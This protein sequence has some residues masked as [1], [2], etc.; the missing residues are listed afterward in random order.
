MADQVVTIP[1][2]HIEADGS[3]AIGKVVNVYDTYAHALAFAA[4]GLTT[5]KTVNRLTGAVGAAISQTA[6]TAGPTVDNNGMLIIALDDKS[7]ERVYWLNSTAGRFGGP[8]KVV[9]SNAAIEE[10]SST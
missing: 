8:L 10:S 2:Q 4:T 6:K 1:M 7:D 5:V 3:S 9:V